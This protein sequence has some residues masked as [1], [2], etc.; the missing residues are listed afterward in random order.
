MLATQ[1]VLEKFAKILPDNTQIFKLDLVFFEI[2]AV[3]FFSQ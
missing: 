2:H 1:G 3:D